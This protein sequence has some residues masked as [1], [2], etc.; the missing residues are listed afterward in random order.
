MKKR[1][2]HEV[3]AS[4]KLCQVWEHVIVFSYRAFNMS[5]FTLLFSTLF[6][7]FR[8]RK[9]TYV[10]VS[11]TGLANQKRG[12]KHAQVLTIY[13]SRCSWF[14]GGDAFFSFEMCRVL[15]DL[16]WGYSVHWR[17]FVGSTAR[18]ARSYRAVDSPQSVFLGGGMSIVFLLHFPRQPQ[19]LHRLCRCRRI[20]QQCR[21]SFLLSCFSFLVFDS[22]EHYRHGYS[23]QNLFLLQASR[24]EPNVL[25]FFLALDR[26]R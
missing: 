19:A 22:P 26:P 10:R 8:S 5:M 3:S 15:G 23:R 17:E 2:F 24:V 20:D 18:S 25:L 1:M 13:Y 12:K 4:S 21:H 7:T 6:G 16:C 9:I 14:W 11:R